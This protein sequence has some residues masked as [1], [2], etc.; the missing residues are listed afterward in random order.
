MSFVLGG[1]GSGVTHY[2]VELYNNSSFCLVFHNQRPPNIN[3]IIYNNKTSIVIDEEADN[4]HRSKCPLLFFSSDE[5]QFLVVNCILGLKLSLR[6]REL[7]YLLCPHLRAVR[8]APL[9]SV[10]SHLI[11]GLDSR[12]SR[13]GTAL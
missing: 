12:D 6:V 5:L 4:P 13:A 11:A 1:L 3:N 2:W 8:A 10:S 9:H 7:V